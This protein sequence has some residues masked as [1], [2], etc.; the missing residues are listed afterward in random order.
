MLN[1][2]IMWFAPNDILIFK[3]FTFC[4]YKT[5]STKNKKSVLKM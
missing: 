3:L 5:D 2:D 1:K 4:L